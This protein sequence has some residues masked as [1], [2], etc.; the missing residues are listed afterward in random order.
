[1][2]GLALDSPAPAHVIVTLADGREAASISVTLLPAAAA[3][4][5]ASTEIANAHR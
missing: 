1:M 5:Q 2:T 3:V 4:T